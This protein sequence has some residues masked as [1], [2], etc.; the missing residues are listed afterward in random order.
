[1]HPTE[2]D[3]LAQLHGEA[4]QPGS[5]TIRRH[6]E[7]CLICLELRQSLGREESEQRRLLRALDVPTPLILVDRFR[8]RAH[9]RRPRVRI[10]ASIGVLVALASAAAA[11]P[12]SPVRDW[13]RG[14]PASA[15]TGPALFKAAL[16]KPSPFA[17]GVQVGAAGSLVVLLGTPQDTGKI[18]ILRT[19]LATAT[20]RAVGGDVGYRVSA[21][22]IHIDNR[23]PA[24][25][26]DIT[27]PRSLERFALLAGGR[28]VLRIDPRHPAGFS[29]SLTIT[30]ARHGGT[31]P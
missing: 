14:R 13:L 21:A 12:G 19:D 27:I 11:I 29:D 8:R 23:L 28:V 25:R 31:T 2:F 4:G 15:A 6:V 26:Y 10:A 24:E 17:D 9:V 7:E 5:G 16:R 20:V 30:F 18:R 1:M 3:L 22:R